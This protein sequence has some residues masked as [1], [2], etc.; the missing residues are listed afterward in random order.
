M[1]E[2][3]GGMESSETTRR[4]IEDLVGIV[5]TMYASLLLGAA[6]GSANILAC[7]STAAKVSEFANHMR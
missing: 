6:E 4:V 3:V 2:C 1:Y 5:G 7:I